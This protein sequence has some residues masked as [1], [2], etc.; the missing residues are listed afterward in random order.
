[1]VKK[2]Y[3]RNI[4]I[5]GVFNYLH[6]ISN[7]ITEF[8]DLI[9]NSSI[10][11]K[12]NLIKLEWEPDNEYD[13][14]AV[15][16]LINN[17]NGDFD[18]LLKNKGLSS[19]YHKIGYLNKNLEDDKIKILEILQEYKDKGDFYFEINNLERIQEDKKVFIDCNIEITLEILDKKMIKKITNPNIL[20]K[21]NNIEISL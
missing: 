4:K 7:F 17:K 14:N 3:K 20:K 12:K 9:E 8:N 18:D 10:K 13:K 2:K 19:E 1:M 21:I 11:T 16:V 5:V 6:S 15:A